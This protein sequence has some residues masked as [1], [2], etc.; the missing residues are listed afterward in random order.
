MAALATFDPGG[1]WLTTSVCEDAACPSAV[2]A[3]VRW[4]RWPLKAESGES[5]DAWNV[6]P[7]QVGA[8]QRRFGVG[9]QERVSL[10]VAAE[11]LGCQRPAPR[12]L[13]SEKAGVCV[14]IRGMSLL[15]VR[16]DR[17]FT[18][19]LCEAGDW[20]YLPSGLPHVFDAGAS[21]DADVLRLCEG[22]G[23]WF[24]EPTGRVLPEALPTMDA[25]VDRLLLEL[26]E[27]LEGGE[28]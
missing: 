14:F 8:L 4:G 27:A 19:L 13:A 17:G 18:G 9:C 21:P 3:G 15:L 26:G 24:P 23:G 1:L 6:D 22:S 12:E 7:V 11:H 5:R 25:F 16:T 2:F 20:V 10:S 28:V